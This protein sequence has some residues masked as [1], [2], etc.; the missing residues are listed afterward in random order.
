MFHRCLFKFEIARSN[1]FSPDE[2]AYTPVEFYVELT[3]NETPK[4]AKRI[5]SLR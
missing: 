3:I 1:A 5:L 2:I 4:P